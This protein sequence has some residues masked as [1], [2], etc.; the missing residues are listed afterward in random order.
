MISIFLSHQ[1]TREGVASTVRYALDAQHRDHAGKYE[2]SAP[3]WHL[4]T[5]ADDFAD[6]IVTAAQ[7][8]TSV[9]RP[10]GKKWDTDVAQHLAFSFPPGVTLSRAERELVEDTLLRVLCPDSP[11]CIA[12]HEPLS[13]DGEDGLDEDGKPRCLHAH[14]VVASATL[15]GRHR[16]TEQRR[17]QGAGGEQGLLRIA[18]ALAVEAVNGLRIE[19]GREDLLATPFEAVAEAR[20]R[21]REVKGHAFRPVSLIVAESLDLGDRV[22]EQS[23]ASTLRGL[24]WKVQ[25]K[26]DSTR[27]ALTP[28]RREEPFYRDLARLIDDTADALAERREKARGARHQ[29]EQQ[30][31]ERPLGPEVES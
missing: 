3:R 7:T 23:V 26:P 2:I 25:K 28:P 29:R 11:A 15:W 21:R 22:D 20:R 14:L 5:N 27:V 17:T 8:M 24:G 18:T 19:Q 30:Q 10:S 4:A 9:R 13:E 31:P 6:H 12:W 1:T 16:L